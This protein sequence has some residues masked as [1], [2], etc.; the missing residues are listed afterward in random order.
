M[1]HYDLSLGI[2]LWKCVS[3]AG[4]LSWTP[5]HHFRVIKLCS[6]G[7]F[8]PSFSRLFACLTDTGKSRM[9]PAPDKC[10]L[11]QV[12]RDVVLCSVF[13]SK[14]GFSLGVFS[15][16]RNE[17]SWGGITRN[18]QVRNPEAPS[19]CR[20]SWLSTLSTLD[21][22]ENHLRQ[23]LSIAAEGLG[24]AIRWS[25]LKERTENAGFLCIRKR[26]S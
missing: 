2:S 14:H 10:S 21:T 9:A 4:C 26:F 22:L 16:P 7:P 6:P 24:V 3:T 5:L 1:S 13:K 15:V 20:E 11:E 12:H 17:V 8:T 19:C 18:Q 23:L 25:S